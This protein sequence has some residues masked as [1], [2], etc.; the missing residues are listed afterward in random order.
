MTSGLCLLANTS[1][2]PWSKFSTS[3]YRAEGGEARALG[4]NRLQRGALQVTPQ[5]GS[6]EK[7]RTNYY[8]TITVVAS[9][10]GQ[11]FLC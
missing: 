5:G 8:Y 6:C 10:V 9:V 1:L 4:G 2:D 3:G 7:S 11:V